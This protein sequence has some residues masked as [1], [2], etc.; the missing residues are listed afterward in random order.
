MWLAEQTSPET[1]PSATSFVQHRALNSRKGL[2][3]CQLLL[4]QDR[5]GK[6]VFREKLSCKQLLEFFATFHGC[7]VVMEACAGT[8]WMA[9]KLRDFGEVQ[10]RL[11]WRYTGE[12]NRS[13]VLGRDLRF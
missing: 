13:A 7:T 1:L 5:V 4:I 3:I 10:K 9:R 6:A 2:G 8:H 12:R 11:F